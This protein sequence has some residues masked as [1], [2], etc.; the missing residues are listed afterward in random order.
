MLRNIKIWD[1]RLDDGIGLIIVLKEISSMELLRRR[2]D[3]LLTRKAIAPIP[4]SSLY[5]IIAKPTDRDA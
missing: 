2:D 1:D 3:R 5:L 4:I